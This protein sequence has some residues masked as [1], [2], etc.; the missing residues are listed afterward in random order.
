VFVAAVVLGGVVGLANPRRG[1]FGLPRGNAV[2]FAAA[3]THLLSVGVASLRG[4]LLVA[5]IALGL[6]WLARQQD[7]LASWLLRA[8]VGMNVLV[9]A[10]NGGMPVDS[11]ALAAVGRAGTDVT[12]GFLYKHVPMTG[13]TRLAWL[14]DRIPV[15]I[16]RNV[17]S[18]GDVLM[19]LAIC[20][21]V[22]DAVA[23][24]RWDRRSAGAVH[25]QHGRGSGGEVVVASKTSHI[26]EDRVG[27]VAPGKAAV[28]L[29]GE[30]GRGR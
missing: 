2:V 20:A 30:V 10:T 8:G 23:S 24:W 18:A 13:E 15:P 17:I 4:P 14:A 7:H 12:E 11:R 28:H 29:D 9:V 16:Q 27:G 22:A 21:W 3:G 25:G 6:W 19:A 5:S 1:R 26:G